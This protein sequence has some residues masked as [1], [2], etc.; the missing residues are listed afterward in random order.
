MQCSTIRYV[1]SNSFVSEPASPSFRKI[2]LSLFIPAASEGA[3]GASSPTSS[4]WHFPAPRAF[5]LSPPERGGRSRPTIAQRPYQWIH[6]C[7]TTTVTRRPALWLCQS[8]RATQCCAWS[9]R[10]F[11]SSRATI[12]RRHGRAPL[13]RFPASTSRWWI[14]ISVS[15]NTPVLTITGLPPAA[16]SRSNEPAWSISPYEHYQQSSDAASEWLAASAGSWP[17]WL[18]PPNSD[19]RLPGTLPSLQSLSRHR[20]MSLIGLSAS[21]TIQERPVPA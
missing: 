16:P 19:A 6:A 18:F 21:S 2:P 5:K 1:P 15:Y 9:F 3:E 10:P 8:S 11:K 20:S 4:S 13:A 12:F 7:G 17:C 14:V